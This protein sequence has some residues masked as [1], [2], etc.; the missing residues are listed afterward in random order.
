[1]R[2]A[3]FRNNAAQSNGG[4][5]AIF[6]NGPS[7]IEINNSIIEGNLANGQGGGIY[8][9]ELVNMPAAL[10]LNNVE[11]RGNEAY[12][13]GGGLSFDCTSL[14]MAGGSVSNNSVLSGGKGGALQ[15]G[16][17]L[18]CGSDPIFKDVKFKGNTATTGAVAYFSS[19]YPSCAIPIL[20][21][22][23]SRWNPSVPSAWHWT[24]FSA[25]VS[26]NSAILGNLQATSPVAI[27]ATSCQ[28]QEV[29]ERQSLLT[30]EGFPG[31]SLFF[32]AMLLDSFNQVT[33]D[34]TLQLELV[35]SPGSTCLLDG[36]LQHRITQG[37]ATIQSVKVLAMVG[38]IWNSI[39]KFK[40]RLPLSIIT[41]KKVVPLEVHLHMGPSAVTCPSGW[42][43]SGG[44]QATRECQACP[45]GSFAVP[46]ASSCTACP[47]GRFNQEAGTADCLVCPPGHGCPAG[48][49]IPAPCPRGYH[50][51]QEGGSS[52]SRCPRGTYTQQTASVNCTECV[53]GMITLETGSD[54]ASS[55]LCSDGSF[56][57]NGKGCTPCPAG[58]LCAAGLAP[59]LQQAG[60][61][62]EVEDASRGLYSVFQCRNADECPEG[63]PEI[64]APGR[65]NLACN[66]C[67]PKYYPTGNGDC[68]ACEDYD[69]L[70]FYVAVIVMWC[71][72]A[73]LLRVMS[74]GISQSSLSKLTVL[75][76]GNQLVMVIQTFSTISKLQIAWPEPVKT[77]IE[78]ADLIMMINL[79]F[80]KIACVS[81]HDH[82]VVKLLGQLLAFPVLALGLGCVW[83]IQKYLKPNQR[84]DH[85]I[86]VLGFILFAFFLSLALA[87]MLPFQCISNPNGT[88]SMANNPGVLCYESED[89]FVLVIVAGV[90]I[91]LY[92]VSIMAWAAW[93]TYLY[94]SRAATGKGIATLYRYRFFFQRF[95]PQC[96]FFGL[97][98]L[99]RNFL[100]ALAPIVLVPVP[101]LQIVAVGTML[102][103]S[104]AL[105]TRLWPWRTRESNV[106]DLLMMQFVVIVLLGVSPLLE[107]DE[108]E[109]ATLLG[110]LLCVPVLA[111]LVLAVVVMIWMGWRSL[112]KT[113]RYDVFLCH[114]KGGAGA[115]ARYIKMQLTTLTGCSV[116]LD[117]DCLESL[118]GLFD[119]VREQTKNFVVILTQELPK[120]MWCAG[121]VATAHK[122]AILTVPVKCDGFLSYTE[123]QI[124]VI[125]QMWSADEQHALSCRG[126]S[127]S[128]V[129]NSLKV[130][131]ALHGVMMPRFG[132][133]AE[134]H[135]AIEKIAL[136][137][138]L[139]RKTYSAENGTTSKARILM[140]GAV[141][142]A[143]ALS[144]IEIC[145][146]MVQKRLQVTC[147]IVRTELEV[148]M[149]MA[150]ASYF[151]VLLSRGM[152][153]DPSFAR[154]LLAATAV[155]QYLSVLFPHAALYQPDPLDKFTGLGTTFGTGL[156]NFWMVPISTTNFAISDLASDIRLGADS[157]KPTAAWLRRCALLQLLALPL[158]PHGSS[159][160]IKKQI[161]EVCGRFRKYQNNAEGLAQD[162][163]SDE[164][165]QKCAN[166]LDPADFNAVETASCS[167]PAITPHLDS[168]MFCPS[169]GAMSVRSYDMPLE[170][171]MESVID[172]KSM[173]RIEDIDEDDPVFVTNGGMCD[174]EEIEEAVR[175]QLAPLEQ[176]VLQVHQDLLP[177]HVHGVHLDQ[178]GCINTQEIP[179]PLQVTAESP[180]L[181][182]PSLP[183]SCL[184][185][186]AVVPATEIAPWKRN[187]AGSLEM[188]EDR[189]AP[190]LSREAPAKLTVSFSKSAMMGEKKRN[191]GTPIPLAKSVTTFHFNESDMPW[192][193]RMCHQLV[194]NAR[195]ELLVMMTLLASSATLG[196]ET[197]V[198][199]QDIHSEPHVIFRIFDITW[200]VAFVLELVFR[201]F[202]DGKMFFSI[203]NP[204]YGWNWMDTFFVAIST[205]DE[206]VVLLGFAI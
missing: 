175:L 22:D 187:S 66:N 69:T 167:S 33:I 169:P 181:P 149:M 64:C 46:G 197:H 141:Q 158:S 52:C 27:V 55:C 29:C 127:T 83:L 21:D 190:S 1:V 139:S 146:H 199:M 26:G 80:V 65:T 119:I 166:S 107:I 126:I 98:L 147:A 122:N 23:D 162:L 109:A 13:G 134:K 136:R 155:V 2:N 79:D 195:F 81:Q 185:Q 192:H 87:T 11:I 164:A 24:D 160:L 150:Y 148:R 193:R 18:R 40:V 73:I 161:E 6:A 50:Q 95:T 71:G 123:S 140:T 114:H 183:S 32:G 157:N 178:P 10:V 7:R 63:K 154:L 30:M 75:A 105:Q 72:A 49:S 35:I 39:C 91:I 8:C 130:L 129:V 128:D 53:L 111:P 191:S 100:L 201:I 152:L 41:L 56:V 94:P 19:A 198:A 153:R 143:E 173:G 61:W 132:R 74:V 85:L 62:A 82:P 184:R 159:A 171:L 3:I 77:L 165:L 93:A 106:A 110:T 142:D 16:Q 17:K 42:I 4:G 84:L 54:S 60:Y 125:P 179:L 135:E 121:E 38:T 108:T 59:P 86:N 189:Q 137:C 20:E 204:E 99:L 116:F 103:A 186:S 70:G 145:Q 14:D 200:C 92:P 174:G 101:A 205:A 28:G 194:R 68:K 177:L 89:H 45:A 88:S 144:V 188:P 12:G 25:A 36:V 115:L 163:E 172:E 44:Q 203:R 102:L 182:P 48:T 117:A 34:D 104:L 96:Y 124:D 120:R 67:L 180:V 113:A 112:Q 9:T 196:V 170:M 206:A 31:M 151:V 156:R 57:V 176:R 90:G 58:M 5:L 168:S 118:D 133:D 76:V 47:A 138:A 37:L 15:V 78:F 202:A 43:S 51:D 97:F 131:L